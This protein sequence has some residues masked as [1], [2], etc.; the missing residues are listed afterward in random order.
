MGVDLKLLP[1]DAEFEIICFSHTVLYLE[2]DQNLF[3]D[4]LAIR[5]QMNVPNNFCS[6]LARTKDNPETHYGITI[7]DAHNQP[8]KYV[9]IESLLRLLSRVEVISSQ[10]NSAVWAY[11]GALDSNTKVA[12]YW[13]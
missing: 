3:N 12:L 10:K 11:L 9:Y 13:H 4:I 5:P 7:V 2:R 1:F 6:Y 8:L